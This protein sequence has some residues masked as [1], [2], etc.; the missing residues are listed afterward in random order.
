MFFIHGGG[1]VGGSG[2]G[3]MAS[4]DYLLDHDVVLVSTNYRVAALGFLSL[5]TDAS[6]GNFGLKDQVMAMKWVQQNVAAFN[7]DP[8]AVTIFGISAGASSVSYQ[9]ISPLSE[10]L[11]HRAILQGGTA[12]TPWGYDFTDIRLELAEKFGQHLNCALGKK[13][14]YSKFIECLRTKDVE[15]IIA[16]TEKITD[17]NQLAISYFVPVAEPESPSAFISKKPSEYRTSHGLKLPIINGF[18][19]QE[20]IL[21]SLGKS[22]NKLYGVYVFNFVLPLSTLC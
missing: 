1:F 21:T 15:E 22:V 14:N 13:E 8:N 17:P 6:P 2:G 7:G 3:V 18:T 10:G 11:F 20:G 5:G 9:L 19:A 12:Y 16:A 4:P